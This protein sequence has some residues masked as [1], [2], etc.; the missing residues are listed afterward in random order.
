M[1]GSGKMLV[2]AVGQHSQLG[3]IYK[4]L[5]EVKEETDETKKQSIIY[6]FYFKLKIFPKHF[7]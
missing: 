6:T 1:E 3:M 7:P 4:L 5:D 2:L